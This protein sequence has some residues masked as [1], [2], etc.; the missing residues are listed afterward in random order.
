MFRNLS[1]Q[2]KLA[3]ASS[4]VMVIFSLALWSALDG[5][6]QT[7]EESERFFEENMVRQTAYQNMFSSGLLSG[8]ALRNLVLKPQLK[9]PYTVVPKAIK[10]FDDEFERIQS[11]PTKDDSVK[12]AYASIQQ[13]WQKSRKAKLEILDLMKSG[14]VEGAKKLLTTVEHPN[15][16]KVR[17][18]V[19]KLTN[20][21]LT[22]NKEVQS[23]LISQTKASLSTTLIIAI[24]ALIVTAFVAYFIL[25]SIKTA[26]QRV[27]ASLNN[28][29][30]GEGDLTQ[31]LEEEGGKEV[32]ELAIA[33]N[34]FVAK[35]QNL[36]QQV[37]SSNQH[38]TSS[39][40]ELTELSVDTKLSVNQQESKIEQVATAMN[41]MAAT[42]QEVARNASH[43][44]ESA[45][46]AD[47][48]S[49]DGQKVVAEVISAINDLASD[50]NNASTTI[51]TLEKDSEQI[52]SILDVIKGI[53]EQTNLLAL[54]AAIE[55]ARA[56]EQ[57]RGFAVVADEVRTL[58]SRT[59]ES[60]QEIQAMIE[61]LQIGAKA[62]V[63]AMEQ[64]QE[65]TLTTVSKAESAG[66]AL[67]TIT[68]AISTIAQQNT[69]IATAAEQQSAVAEEIN[70]N[71]V[72][73]NALATQ[74]AQ[75]AEHTAASSQ[76]LERTADEL[77]KMISIFKI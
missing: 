61:K 47:Q 55:A 1:I 56:G 45:L 19:Q 60:T 33:F 57:G 77:Q 13:S 16:R 49:T 73:I 29:A 32:A 76:E 50:V 52:G 70:Q 17:I 28:I 22:H 59:Q 3:A 58:A 6:L 74:A 12:S 8:L 46:A 68:Q 71:V 36:I 65:K 48:E 26:F 27:T 38:L 35:I 53:A 40:K 10:R 37:A 30:Q 11:M 20:S 9:K 14:N 31:R 41:E 15:W 44:S 63:E 34:L 54:N 24:L 72:S 2:A 43:A 62:A 51:N 7:S 75:G 64:G 5:M 18:E 39:V 66:Q 21:E 67:A 23:S 69:Q 4:V 42:V 25:K